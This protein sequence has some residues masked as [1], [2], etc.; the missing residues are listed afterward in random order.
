M[1]SASATETVLVVEDEEGVRPAGASG[2]LGAGYHVLESKDAESAVALCA[3]IRDPSIC[4][5]PMW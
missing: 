2:S 4:S 1:D 3:A 5:L